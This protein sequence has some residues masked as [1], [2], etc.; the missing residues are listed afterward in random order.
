MP[1]RAS[2]RSA[3]STGAKPKSCGSS[4]ETP[5]PAIRAI[6]SSPMVA[7][8][9]SEPSSTAEAPSLSGDALPAVIVPVRA[10]GR[11][12][13]GELLGG[14]P[15]TD[16]LVA[17]EVDAG[18]RHD[19]VVVEPGLP[20][21]VGQVVRAG[22]EL[23]LPLAAR[24][25]TSRRSCSLAS[26]SETVHSAGIRSLTSRQPSVV[27]T[28]VTLPAGNARD[29]LGST[30]GARVIDSTPPVSTTSASPDSMVRDPMIAASSDEPQSRLTVVAGTDTGSPASST[31]HPADVA[32]VLAGL[33]GAAPHDV[34]DRGRVEARGLREHA[35]DR[36]GGEVVGAHLGERAAEAAE[37]RAGGG[38]Q[39]CGGHGSPSSASTCWAIRNAVLAS[40]TPQ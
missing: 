33:V 38:V 32:V 26:P 34:A 7:A 11:L 5:R 40:G 24:C 8:A 25:G 4:A 36:G 16:A 31:R 21:R 17:G 18:H 6:G 27:E 23:V 10:E 22:G 15:G 30:H 29:G 28:A 1:A 39:E 19:Q 2:A 37:R 14:R 13:P 35:L 12:Q 3:A 20:G 9:A